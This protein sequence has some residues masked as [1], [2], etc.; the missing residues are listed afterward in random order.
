L[1]GLIEATIVDAFHRGRTKDDRPPVVLEQNYFHQDVDDLIRHIEEDGRVVRDRRTA[2][3]ALLDY[4]PRSWNKLLKAAKAGLY[5]ESKGFRRGTDFWSSQDNV[6]I[7]R[8]RKNAKTQQHRIEALGKQ[9]NIA[10]D[11]SPLVTAI[12]EWA[13]KDV[14][15]HKGVLENRSRFTRLGTVSFKNAGRLPAARTG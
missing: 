10:G 3:E 14:C 13:A 9:T 2:E 11:P 15:P 6:Y 8:L 7:E 12:S 1:A 4:L 5:E